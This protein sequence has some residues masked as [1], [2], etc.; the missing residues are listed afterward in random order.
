MRPQVLRD[1]SRRR[2]CSTG[3]ARPNSVAGLR[4]HRQ[5]W[6]SRTEPDRRR[7]A[8]SLP[9]SRRSHVVLPSSSSCRVLSAMQWT[10]A[11]RGSRLIR[12]CSATSSASG[13]IGKR[14]SPSTM[15]APRHVTEHVAVRR[16][17]VDQPERHPGVRRMEQRALALD[18]QHLASAFDPLDDEA[19]RGAGDEVGDHRV[20]GDPPPGDR[21]PRLAGRD[22]LAAVFR[23]V[24]P[25]GRARARRSS[26][27]SR[28][29]S[30]RSGSSS[31]RASGSRRSEHRARRA[32]AAG[33]AAPPRAPRRARRARGRSRR[34]RAARSRGRA[35][36]RG[37]PR[38]DRRH[39]GGKRPPCVA[40]P[41]SAVVGPKRQ[42]F[43]DGLDDRGKPFD[44]RPR[45][46]LES[47]SATI[48]SGRYRITPRA[49]LPK[50]GIARPPFGEDEQPTR[51]R[52]RAPERRRA[53]ARPS[54]NSTPGHGSSASSRLPSRST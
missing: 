7:G 8:P 23:A 10:L 29:P 15:V 34:T 6:P 32:A 39:A 33:R 13:G 17:A 28:S 20:D 11:G 53:A 12:S 2:E 18:E 14:S 35:R 31:P 50:C 46:S 40:T 45:R 54:T 1:E 3:R 47:R 21:D 49:V 9:P 26:S 52:H 38:A 25:R 43:G 16:R 41:T 19:L 5:A 30:R 51:A 37:S 48:S 4:A 27:R 36:L 42:S 44:G 22:E 24:A